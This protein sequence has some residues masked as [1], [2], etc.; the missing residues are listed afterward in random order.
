MKHSPS[1]FTA[2]NDGCGGYNIVDAKSRTIGATSGAFSNDIPVAEEDANAKLF[3]AS[4]DLLAVV[5]A[6]LRAP[7]VGSSGAGSVAISVTNFNLEAAR[8]DQIRRTLKKLGTQ[9]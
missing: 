4:P 9:F 7:S 3:A 8:A 2:K 1:P 5:R 6:F